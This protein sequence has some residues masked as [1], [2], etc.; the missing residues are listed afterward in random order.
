MVPAAARGSTAAEGPVPSRP[1]QRTLTAAVCVLAMAPAVAAT[2]V[3]G[4]LQGVESLS[5]TAIPEA[6]R[7][8][9]SYW[10]VPNGTVALTTPRA[11]VEADVAV[12]VTGQ[13]VTEASQPVTVR[14][15][16]GRCRPGTLVVTPGTVLQIDNRD[17]LGHELYA[18]PRGGGDRVVAAELTSAGTRR[19]V[20][21]PSAGVFELRD[22]RQPTFRCWVIAGPGQ[23]RVI[24][25]AAD[26]GFTVAGLADGEYTARAYYEGTERGSAAFRVAGRD[27]TVTVALTAAT[28]TAGTPTAGT[29]AGG[30]PTGG[31]P[32]GAGA[33]AATAPGA[34]AGAGEGV[35]AHGHG[36]GR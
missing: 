29:P 30:T 3:R 5:P 12:V 21:F 1:H 23:G 34:G 15:E 36:Q 8:R 28:P 32:T 11:S 35:A 27:A 4:T 19:Q 33:G 13:G 25:P 26:N 22:V 16:G 2:D 9:G 24:S 7:Y 20:T 6:P 14:V 18:V 17:V 31:T 10:E